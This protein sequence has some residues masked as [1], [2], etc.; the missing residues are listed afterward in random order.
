MRTPRISAVRS[1][2][3][4]S[5]RCCRWPAGGRHR[6]ATVSRAVAKRVWEAH[7]PPSPTP[8]VMDRSGI[9]WSYFIC[10]AFGTRSLPAG[11]IE[12]ILGA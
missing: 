8:V 11:Y 6:S 7:V 5:A 12:P 3:R 9:A 1:L 10:R 2:T 4:P